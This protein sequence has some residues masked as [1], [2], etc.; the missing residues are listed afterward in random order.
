[1]VCTDNEGVKDVLISCQTESVN[2]REQDVP[3]GTGERERAKKKMSHGQVLALGPRQEGTTRGKAQ[4]GYVSVQM[5]TVE[6]LEQMRRD[7]EADML[8]TVTADPTVLPGK[9]KVTE[10]ESHEQDPY[11]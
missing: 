3:S 6:N 1:M 9:G 5:E 8:V 7:Q 11:Q 10:F 4:L 2:F